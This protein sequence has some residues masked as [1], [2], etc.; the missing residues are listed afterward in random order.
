MPPITG[1]LFFGDEGR[2][3]FGVLTPPDPR[4]SD[5]HAGWLFCPPFGEERDN[6]QRILV[7]WSRALSREGF[8]VLR[9]DLSGTGNSEGTFDR[10]TLDDWLDDV[11]QAVFVLCTLTGAP[12]AGL[13]G[14]RLGA[15]LAVLARR[16]LGL[17][18]PLLLWAPVTNGAAF[19][20][21]QLRLATVTEMLRGG[22][23]PATRA[24]LAARLARGETVAVRGH[25][26]SPTLYESIRRL[27][28]RQESDL[29]AGPSLVVQVDPK[30]TE[31]TSAELEALCEALASGGRVDLVRATL[32]RPW[33]RTA[34]DYT[35]RPR[36]L[37]QPSLDWARANASRTTPAVR[38]VQAS[39]I[40]PLGERIV[41]FESGGDRLAGIL[42]VPDGYP[43]AQP[44]VLM[45]VM[46]A[47]FH[48]R[49][50]RELRRLGFASLRFDV[51]GKGESEGDLPFETIAALHRATQ[52][53]YFASDLSAAADFIE[54]EMGPHPI[55]PLGICGEGISGLY[56]ACRDRRVLGVAPLEMPLRY[57][58]LSS[59]RAP[60]GRLKR[61]LVDRV[62]ARPH[63]VIRA[64]R[65]ALIAARW[66]ERTVI[67]RVRRGFSGAATERASRVAEPL[68]EQANLEL[69]DALLRSLDRGVRV[70]SVYGSQRVDGPSGF[71]RILPRLQVACADRVKQIEYHLLEGADHHFSCPDHRAQVF[72]IVVSWLAGAG[73][74]W[75]QQT[76]PPRESPGTP[77]EGPK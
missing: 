45:P 8:W 57:A 67:A 42:S 32:S 16:R 66:F 13:C 56:L 46:S 69:L 44:V 7:E 18:L 52:G 9:F 77:E 35:P 63:P 10:F 37:F 71:E 76:P 3:L 4:S 61:Y 6:A 73:W 53:G 29:G 43:T 47:L 40:G 75:S 55:V 48:V 31:R 36:S 1:P 15:T 33:T 62:L 51:H 20:D 65:H 28:L 23:T 12:L 21:E 58:P 39:R 49:L 27:D 68:G 38:E 60:I 59:A 11:H 72:A 24:G 54:Q 34:M 50:A 19:M 25:E 26:M 70:L 41:S 74:P 64:A 5:R 17:S 14:L 22:G 30:P 2:R